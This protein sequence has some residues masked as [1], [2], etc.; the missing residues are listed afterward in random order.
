MAF[1]EEYPSLLHSEEVSMVERVHRTMDK[2]CYQNPHRVFDTPYQWL[3]FYNFERIHLS[4]NS[5]TPHEKYLESVTLD[6]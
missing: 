5:K 6:C 2:E 1:A 4:L 3:R